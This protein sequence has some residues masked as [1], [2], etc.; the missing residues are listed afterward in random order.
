MPMLVAYSKQDALAKGVTRYL[1]ASCKRGHEGWRKLDGHCVECD[2][3]VQ[4]TYNALNKGRHNLNDPKVLAERTRAW[5]RANPGM[6][7]AFSKMKRER[8]KQASCLNTPEENEA[9]RQFYLA[10]PVGMV[11]DHVVPLKGKFVCGLHR[12]GNMQYLTDAANAAKGNRFPIA[13][14]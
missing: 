4:S 6:V 2:R 5:R 12:I 8:I 7:A 1:G 9:I 11:V 14:S 10:C 13:S 3:K